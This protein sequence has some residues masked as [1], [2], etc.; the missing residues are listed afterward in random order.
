M[1]SR[2]RFLA[3][4][5]TGVVFAGCV[6][7]EDNGGVDN[8]GANDQNGNGET[9][10]NGGNGQDDQNGEADDNDDTEEEDE[11]K[12]EEEDPIVEEPPELDYPDPRFIVSSDG[13]GDYETFEEAER[14]A[15]SGDVIG[16][17][18]EEYTIDRDKSLVYVGVETTPRIEF[19]VEDESIEVWNIEI[20]DSESRDGRVSVSSLSAYDSTV[21]FP[22]RAES[23]NAVNSIFEDDVMTL[24]TT[25]SAEFSQFHG[26][27][28]QAD[29]P[30]SSDDIELSHCVVDGGISTPNGDFEAE[31]CVLKG[32]VHTESSVHIV[33]CIVNGI[34]VDHN[35]S[36]GIRDSVLEQNTD[37]GAAIKV[38]SF[39]GTLDIITNCEINGKLVMDGNQTDVSTV[40]YN[41]FNT[42]GEF[43]WFIDGYGPTSLYGNSFNGADIRID[44]STNNL[45]NDE[46]GN[47]YSEWDDAGDAEQG[48]Y[49]LP[50]PIPGDAELTDNYPLT[51]EAVD[52]QHDWE[53][54]NAIKAEYSE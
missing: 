33:G 4:V 1:A 30:G 11:E 31:K 24:R 52:E 5:G 22:L 35:T 39:D 26:Q 6:S 19:N 12:E 13:D 51:E 3:T 27:V 9:T 46:K 45:Y 41:L 38:T 18:D 21:T 50:R 16:L 43:D 47:Y 37:I 34:H 42:N 10:D 54:V 15:D 20:H 14:V 44:D 25:L 32:L 49:T 29:P 23:F 17:K 36:G 40:R 2:R 8:R 28:T 7:D 53:I 48:V